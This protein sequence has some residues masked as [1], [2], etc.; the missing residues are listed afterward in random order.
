MPYENDRKLIT[1]G[2]DS[3]AGKTSMFIYHMTGQQPMEYIPIKVDHHVEECTINGKTFQVIYNDHEGGG[4]DWHR[5]RHF[6]YINSDCVVL[7]FNI[8][9]PD[10]F[11]R[12]KEFWYPF[13]QQH[14]PKA[15]LLL[16]GMKKDLRDDEDVIKELAKAKEKPVTYEEGIKLSKEIHAECYLECSTSLGEGIEDVFFK[17]AKIASEVSIDHGYK[18]RKCCIL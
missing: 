9:C 12:M 6:G 3:W 14:C 2:G 4:E 7:C 10:S 5:L 1:F 18:K 15:K 13:T 17:A 8:G 16:V 11:V